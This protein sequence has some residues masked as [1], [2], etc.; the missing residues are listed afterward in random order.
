MNKVIAALIVGM[1]AIAGAS[2]YAADQP[3]QTMPGASAKEPGTQNDPASPEKHHKNG[4]KK[5]KTGGTSPCAG[6]GAPVNAPAGEAK[7]NP[8]ESAK[9]P[10]TK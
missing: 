6:Q 5:V 10:G 3:V 7:C 8:E 2:V 1:F 9:K 4:K